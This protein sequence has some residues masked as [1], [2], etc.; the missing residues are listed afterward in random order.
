MFQ[1]FETYSKEKYKTQKQ[2]TKTFDLVFLEF[3]Q[4]DEH[5]GDNSS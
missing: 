1:N 4:T 5:E 2:I 3:S